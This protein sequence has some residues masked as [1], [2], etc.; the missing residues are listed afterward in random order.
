MPVVHY[1]NFVEGAYTDVGII[2]VPT[3]AFANVSNV[4]T[5]Y[6]LGTPMKRPGYVIKGAALEANKSITGLFNFRQ[7][8]ATQKM[9]ATVNDSGDADTQLFY[10]TGGAWTEIA[11][12]ETAWATFEDAKVEMENFI[13][14]CFFVGYDSTDS[15]FL[16][17]A[18][19]TGTTFSTSTNTTDMPQAKFI[20]RYRDRLYLVNCR[21]AGTNYPYRIYYSGVPSG[22][23]VAWDLT[24]N[25]LDVDFSE[26][27]TGMG[28]NW[29][30]AVF[31][32]EYSAYMYNQSE[33]KKSWDVGCS[34]HR[35]IKNSGAYMFWAN[36]DGVWASTG[37]RPENVAGRIIDFVRA[38]NPTNWFSEVVDEEYHIYFGTVTVNGITYTNCAGILNVPTQTW[39]IHEYAN[40]M[41]VFAKYYS[42]GQDHLWM[43]TTAGNV[44]GLGKYTDSTLLSDD[45]GSAIQSWFQTGALHLGDPSVEKT[46]SKITAYADRAQGLR[47]KTRV[48]DRNN[49]GVT[50]WQ[51]MGELKKYINELQVKSG[52]GNFIQIEG[53]EHGKNPYWSLL[54]LS[55]LFEA[56]KP[57]NK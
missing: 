41:T 1:T 10:S 39:R 21:S 29:D 35:T 56:N 46:F 6:K 24:N 25:F 12:A 50:D 36:R 17:V 8:A 47:L 57:Y 45:N 27:L 14:Y 54:G 3:N 23:T 51:P 30:R 18:T 7:T 49:Q 40:N 52:D 9:L 53:T 55:V 2:N 32:T 34:N 43:G 38:S 42:A 19:L 44:M 15:V 22:A 11:A 4:V 16:P 33:F 26:E 37:G 28:E 48:I 13:S 20:K 31:F 5:S